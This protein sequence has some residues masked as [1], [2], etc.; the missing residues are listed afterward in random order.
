[1]NE[2]ET[3]V[4][5]GDDLRAAI[6]KD[7]DAMTAEP[8]EQ[9][10]QEKPVDKGRDE[11]GRFAKKEE[12]AA[13]EAAPVEQEIETQEL[14]PET[15]TEQKAIAPPVHWSGSA[16]VRWDKL[17]ARVQEAIS[18]DYAEMSEKSKGIE[19]LE[20]V[21]APRRQALTMRYGDVERGL[22]TMFAY[23]DALDKDPLGT[24]QYI[25]RERGI[26]L[27]QLAPQ[28]GQTDPQNAYVQQIQ[29]LQQQLAQVNQRFESGNVQAL[30]SQID[31]FAADPKHPYFQDVKTEMGALIQA[32]HVR[33]RQMTLEEAYERA[34][35]AD[36]LIRSELM[37]RQKEQELAAKQQKLQQA[38]AAQPIKGAPGTGGSVNG[39]APAT[40]RAT[41]EEAWNALS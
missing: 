34:V 23:A 41:I 32:A 6:E 36:P 15:T 13:V 22:N 11:K 25:A 9:V 40:I 12:P 14:K 20:R 3:T 7:F 17:P 24:L 10:E 39:A 19:P 2:T 26:D 35:N 18:K 5:G 1:M 37:E 33:G 29:Q 38:K 27:S 30:Q 4:D 28:Q 21:I 31:A 8:V 16:K